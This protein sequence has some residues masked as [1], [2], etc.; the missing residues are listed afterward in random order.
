[1]DN[2][3]SNTKSTNNPNRQN[4]P[5]Y[6]KQKSRTVTFA[7]D[8]TTC[9]KGCVPNLRDKGNDANSE[10]I[11][12]RHKGKIA[13]VWKPRTLNC[14]AVIKYTNGRIKYT[15]SNIR[16]RC[17]KG[18]QEKNQSDSVLKHGAGPRD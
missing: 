12:Q 16:D 9:G 5:G 6:C 2:S 18:L 4:S 13:M 17:D 15:D 3:H 7:A 11:P 8:T 14:D 1:M 10:T